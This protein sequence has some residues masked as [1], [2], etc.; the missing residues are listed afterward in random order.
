M[1][2]P[3]NDPET[4]GPIVLFIVGYVIGAITAGALVFMVLGY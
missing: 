4:P 1:S 3:W 2:H